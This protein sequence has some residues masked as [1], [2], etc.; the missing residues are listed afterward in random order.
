MNLLNMYYLYKVPSNPPSKLFN[1]SRSG[2]HLVFLIDTKSLL[3]E[4]ILA[5]V[6]VVSFF[7]L[8]LI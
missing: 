3:G 8:G 1:M 4:N 6:S 2:D 5:N 7:P